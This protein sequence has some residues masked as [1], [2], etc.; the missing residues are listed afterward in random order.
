[1]DEVTFQS[2]QVQSLQSRCE[3]IEKALLDAAKNSETRM[4]LGAELVTE[5]QNTLKTLLRERQCAARNSPDRTRLSKCIQKEVRRRKREN[6]RNQISKMLEKF[7]Q[8]KRIP[9]IKTREKNK[10]IN[11]MTDK[12]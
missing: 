5:D 10:F 9:R 2:P 6:R 3:Q 4:Q 8:L 11:Q 1:M 7:K 12:W